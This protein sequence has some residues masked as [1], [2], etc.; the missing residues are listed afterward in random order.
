[1][2]QECLTMPAFEPYPFGFANHE[3]DAAASVEHVEAPF[4]QRQFTV[5]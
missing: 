4:I 2:P 5:P 3:A 1:M